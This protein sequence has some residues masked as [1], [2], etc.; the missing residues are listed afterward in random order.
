MK[1]R[2]L[3]LLG[4]LFGLFLSANVSADF[5]SGDDC[6]PWEY[7]CN[8]WPEWTPM[9]WMEEMSD[10]W[11]DDDDD[12]WRYGMM[13][14]YGGM[15]GPYG[16]PGYG[17]PGPYGMPPM[18]YGGGYGAPY[19]YGAPPPYG[20]PPAYGAPAAPQGGHTHP[21]PPAAPAAPATR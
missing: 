12:Y 20:A 19:G 4:M 21:H 5:F 11:D 16:M 14:P 15:P 6:P 17:M 2:S 10:G 8:D 13:G 7:D 3:I 9:Y 18:P 1:S